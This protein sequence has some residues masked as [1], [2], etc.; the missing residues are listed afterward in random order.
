MERGATLRFLYN[1]EDQLRS[2]VNEAGDEYM[3]DL[4]AQGNVEEEKGFDGLTRRYYRDLA[5]Q[6]TAVVRP[7]KRETDYE[8]DPCGRVTKV[9]YNPDDDK[10]RKEETYEYRR[11]GALIKAVNADAEVILERDI[12]GRV[13]KETC[14]GTEV[15]SEYDLSGN[16]THVTSSLGADIRADYNIMGDVVSLAGGGWQTQYLRDLFGLET[17]RTFAGGVMAR[18]ERDSLGRVV[19]QKTERNNR[20]LSEK[21]YLWGANDRLLSVVT[22][23]KTK[24]FEYDVWGNLSKTVFED[25]KNGAS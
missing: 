15:A 25:G 12:L 22:D 3:F 5:G 18:T 11:D 7:D 16:R 21:S 8:Y 10:K 1:T 14:N 9:I 13:T 20:Y 24:H 19:S 2:V 23:G 17:G 6:V 4:D